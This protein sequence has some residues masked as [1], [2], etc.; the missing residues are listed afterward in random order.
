MIIK[1][2]AISKYI[3]FR[4]QTTLG[5][6]FELCEYNDFCSLEVPK[7]GKTVI[8]YKPVVDL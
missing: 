4:T 5:N 1:I 8:R 3:A 2:P 6:H 7:E